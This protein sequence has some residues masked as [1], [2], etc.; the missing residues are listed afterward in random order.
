MIV[1]EIRK[2][3]QTPRELRKFGCVVGGVFALLGVWCYWRGKPAYPLLLAVACPLVVLGA[4]R[5]SLLRWP[6]LIWMSF[7]IILGNA[8]S[9]VILTV[10][11]YLFL[12]PLGIVARLT[13]KDF[14][15]RRMD[16]HAATYWI[17]RARRG[18]NNPQRYERQF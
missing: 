9:T 4:V 6:H 10:F 3:S 12:T 7:G 2:L 16:R 11:Y 17:A 8:V 13:G 5:P 15:S 1:R 18:A 14:L